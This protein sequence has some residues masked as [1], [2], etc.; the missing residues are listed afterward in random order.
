MLD[1]RRL[2]VL[3]NPEYADIEVEPWIFEIIRVTAVKGHLL[4]RGKNEADIIIALVAVEM[5][6]AALIESHDVAAQSGLLFAFLL[7]QGNGA[8][9]RAARPVRR[10]ARFHGGIHAGRNILDGSQD[11]QL[12][13]SGLDFIG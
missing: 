11:I 8:G 5:I 1:V 7:D 12:E 6:C 13:I 9:A 4:F 10:L 3:V 2:P